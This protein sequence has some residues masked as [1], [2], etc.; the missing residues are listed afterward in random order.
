MLLVSSPL[1]SILCILLPRQDV[2]YD[3]V[4]W[5]MILSCVYDNASRSSYVEANVDPF[6]D[7]TNGLVSCFRWVVI[8]S[9]GWLRWLR[10]IW[11]VRLLP[12]SFEANCSLQFAR[13]QGF[14]LPSVNSPYSVNIGKILVLWRIR[15][16]NGPCMHLTPIIC[17]RSNTFKS[18]ALRIPAVETTHSWQ[19]Q[20]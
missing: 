11:L 5:T 19:P 14:S 20:Y 1:E 15:I 16:L 4:H 3:C 12:R 2:Q 18:R 13:L 17:P 7:C 9:N 10:T 6:I 8:W